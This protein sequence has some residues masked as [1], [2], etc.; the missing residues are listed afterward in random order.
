MCW[1]MVAIWKYW[2]Y[3]PKT[4]VSAYICGRCAYS[5]KWSTDTLRMKIKIIKKQEE[6]S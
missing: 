3:N 5:G 2:E 6:K 4:N 1:A